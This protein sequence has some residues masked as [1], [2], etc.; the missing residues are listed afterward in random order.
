MAYIKQKNADVYIINAEGNLSEHPA[1]TE[2]PELFEVVEGTPPEN[3]E[4]LNFS[5]AE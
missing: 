1:I 5:A 3:F 2:Y 4:R